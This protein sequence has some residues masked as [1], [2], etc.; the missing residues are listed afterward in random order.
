MLALA[1]ER[2]GDLVII[3]GDL[4]EHL[5]V[6][7]DT[8]SFLKGAFE[9]LGTKPICV[10]PGNHDPYIH[11]SP[12][13]TA[14]WPSNV[15]IFRE[16]CWSSVDFP[17]LGIR[18]HGIAHTSFQDSTDQLRN[19]RIPSDNRLHIAVMHGS[20]LGEVPPTYEHRTYFPFRR[21]ELERCGAH[22]TALGHYHSFKVLTGD[23]PRPLGCY[24][25]CP[26]GM[27]FDEEGCK[28]A[29]LVQLDETQTTVEPLATSQRQYVSAA[30]DCTG[31][32]SRDDIIKRL[33]AMAE[34]QGWG[35]WLVKVA[36]EGEI[37]PGVDLDL[38]DV[39][40][41]GRGDLYCLELLNR[42]M[43]SY[44]LAGVRREQSARGEF[45]RRVE[46]LL[47]DLPPDQEAEREALEL[48]LTFGLDAFFRREIPER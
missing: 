26:E 37:E 22:Y 9:S 15:H 40:T 18:V 5:R 33:R 3:A 48:A 25:G 46:S 11:D 24:S 8:I 28:V 43:P 6:T 44:D 12:Y 19:L 38:E 41:R 13:A 10:A 32:G 17:S 16:D 45:V 1:Q 27:G 47:A 36:L 4:F 35:G 20:D 14:E 42:T 2:R 23:T 7:R 29:L 31:A 21:G 30:L 39:A 34:Q